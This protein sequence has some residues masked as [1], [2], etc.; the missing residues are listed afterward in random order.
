MKRTPRNLTNIK[1]IGTTTI[2]R[3]ETSFDSNSILI[4]IGD[5]PESTSTKTE[6]GSHHRPW[7]KRRFPSLLASQHLLDVALRP[8][9]S[10]FQQ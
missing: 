4:L 5:E 6:W 10:A 8:A 1:K 3:K 9:S 7:L 2:R